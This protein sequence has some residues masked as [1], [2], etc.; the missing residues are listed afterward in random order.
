MEKSARNFHD[1]LS[2]NF[3]WILS[4]AS[5]GTSPQLTKA[6]CG[7]TLNWVVKWLQKLRPLLLTTLS[8]KN[9]DFLTRFSLN[10]Q[11]T[12]VISRPPLV[13]SYIRTW[14]YRLP[15]YRV[16]ELRNGKLQKASRFKLVP[17]C[18]KAPKERADNR[19][20]T[21]TAASLRGTIDR[22]SPGALPLVPDLHPSCKLHHGAKLDFI[23]Q[24][25]DS[26]DSGK[27]SRSQAWDDTAFCIS[28][29]FQWRLNSLGYILWK[30]K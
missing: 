29:Q 9:G 16:P 7:L 22:F 28:L 17:C 12:A 2:S 13:F 11:Y 23:N 25:W 26:G 20:D 24:P 3:R 14:K 10:N 4:S 19:T 27:L 15:K 21:S 1:R 5:T 6:F 8:F 18:G 30:G